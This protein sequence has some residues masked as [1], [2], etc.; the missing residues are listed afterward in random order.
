MR[1][2]TG[3]HRETEQRRQHGED[4]CARAAGWSHATPSAPFRLRVFVSP[5]ETVVSA[6]SASSVNSPLALAFMR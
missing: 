5:C 3:I 4:A 1:E 2:T 6:V